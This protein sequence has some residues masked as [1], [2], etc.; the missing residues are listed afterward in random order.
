MQTGNKN[1][2]G[3]GTNLGYAINIRKWI[4]AKVIGSLATFTGRLVSRVPPKLSLK[5]AGGGG[6]GGG[7]KRE[8]EPGGGGVWG[9]I[10]FFSWGRGDPGG[11]NG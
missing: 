7:G 6:G 9:S 11:L 8:R 5:L 1:K 4:F 3:L 10:I 2:V